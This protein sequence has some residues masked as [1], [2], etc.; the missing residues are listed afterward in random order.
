MKNFE[1][2]IRQKYS[3]VEVPQFSEASWDRFQSHVEKKEKKSQ[4][5]GLLWL[6]TALLLLLIS[7]S[8]WY[9]NQKDK[10]AELFLASETYQKDDV[11]KIPAKEIEQEDHTQSVSNNGASDKRISV[12]ASV[13]ATQNNTKA[14]INKSERTKNNIDY[15]T[16]PSSENLKRFTK[17]LSTQN[18]TDVEILERAS[19]TNPSMDHARSREKIFSSTL[20]SLNTVLSKIDHQKLE[21]NYTLEPIK[22]VRTS[23]IEKG[24]SYGL[25]GSYG[26]LDHKV[27]ESNRLHNISNTLYFNYGKYFRLKTDVGL[28]NIQYD[29]RIFSLNLGIEGRV[30]E[31]RSLKFQKVENNVNKIELGIGADLI[32]PSIFNTAVFAG[33]SLVY[34]RE[35]SRSL[36]YQFQ[37]E[38]NKAMETLLE[39]NYELQKFPLNLRY[40]IGIKHVVSQKYSVQAIFSKLKQLRKSDYDMP[41]ETTYALGLEIKL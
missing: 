34:G 31:S 26:Y 11:R 28:D 5:R 8:A 36:S 40:D 15:V 14:K 29:T 25:A 2:N 17:N 30:A 18:V 27:I 39:N 33:P 6:F 10:G 24:F 41:N 21:V 19:T 38:E 16:T 1:E 3:E 37:D 35:I 23:H 13:T 32:S 12:Q 7:A 22:P 9:T 4:R 20:P